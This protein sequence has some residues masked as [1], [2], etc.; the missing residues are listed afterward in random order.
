[1]SHS[2]ANRIFTKVHVLHHGFPLC[3]FSREVPADWPVGHGWIWMRSGELDDPKFKENACKPC[4]DK[5]RA[6]T[7]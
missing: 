1:M 7:Q 4:F 2:K 5:A 3:E 6:A